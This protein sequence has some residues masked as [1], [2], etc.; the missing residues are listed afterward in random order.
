MIFHSTVIIILL[1]LFIY[2]SYISYEGFNTAYKQSNYSPNTN[3]PIPIARDKV[4]KYLSPNEDGNCPG[5][6]ERNKNDVNSLCHTKCK[7]DAKF[8]NVQGLIH[9]CVILDKSYNATN[10]TYPFAKDKKTYI[11]SPK[12]DGSCPKNFILD[13]TSGICHTPCLDTYTFYGN[14]GCLLLNKEYPQ[15]QFSSND[16]PYPS[17]E[18]G[19]NLIISPTSNAVCPEGFNLDYESGLC[20][21]PC[22]KGQFYGTKSGSKVIGCR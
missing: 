12:P 19:N 8:Y 20:H 7:E 16:T 5:G 11:V 15:T 2:I 13:T 1:L 10:N 18:D 14:L 6:Y 3:T 21:T 4:T 9:G 17:T 22:E